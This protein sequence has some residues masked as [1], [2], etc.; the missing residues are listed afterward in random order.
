MEEFWVIRDGERIGPFAEDEILRGY[1]SGALQGSDVLWAQGM[2]NGATVDEA[3][4]QL[5]KD[6]LT[7]SQPLPLDAITPPA[8][9]AASPYAPPTA[10]VADVAERLSA[11]TV[12][13]GF[14]VRFAAVVL[15]GLVLGVLG[16][17]IGFVLGFAAG[18]LGLGVRGTSALGG[19]AGAAI[20]WLYFAITES[21]QHRAS[22]GKRA[23]RLQ[24]L[25]ADGEQRVSFLRATGRWAARYLSL[26]LLLIGYLMQPFTA[27]KQALH[28]LLAGTVVVA[29]APTRR[30]LVALMLA[31]A[32]GLPIAGFVLGAMLKA[33]GMLGQ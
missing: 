11:P 16:A 20:G 13:A 9:A 5:R 10:R 18:L 24:V 28:D 23:L 7:S 33:M 22:P 17:V 6:I 8:D 25:T 26:L 2:T 29:I 32:V 30:W 3:F 21:S 19:V 4:A 1:E 15:D 12:F 14:W 27:R 31:L